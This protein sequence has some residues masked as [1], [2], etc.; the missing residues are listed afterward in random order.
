MAGRD[1]KRKLLKMEIMNCRGLMASV[2]GNDKKKD[3]WL[4]DLASRT[5]SLV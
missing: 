4:A 2:Q 5:G 3:T 1:K